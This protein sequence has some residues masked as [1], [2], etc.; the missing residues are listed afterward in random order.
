M[1]G[2]P[3]V[4]SVRLLAQFAD[5]VEQLSYVTER[6][7]F[8]TCMH[9]LFAAAMAAS[10]APMLVAI[11]PRGDPLKQLVD[12]LQ[13]LGNIARV[14]LKPTQRRMIEAI[15]GGAQTTDAIARSLG[16][17]KPHVVAIQWSIVSILG[18]EQATRRRESE[19]VPLDERPITDLRLWGP[20]RV[21][22]ETAGVETVGQLLRFSEK[23]LLLF[24]LS[25]VAR[26]EHI[27]RR[28]WASGERTLR[29]SGPPTTGIVRAE[30]RDEPS[31]LLVPFSLTA[32][33][34]ASLAKHAALVASCLAAGLLLNRL[35]SRR[36]RHLPVLQAA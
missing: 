19:A 7:A 21:M 36:D 22:L 34:S 3:K 29:D 30:S 11:E 8:R 24:P 35:A 27:K 6:D 17:S 16:I 33:H 1:Q 10:S 18:D 28:L 23:E 32:F 26:V 20:A 13:E 31:F 14:R 25:G 15:R 9:V 5:R 4:A 12:L 2:R